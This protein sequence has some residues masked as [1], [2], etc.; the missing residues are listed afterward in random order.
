MKK[1]LKD[2]IFS[3][4]SYVL[5]I[6]VSSVILFYIVCKLLSALQKV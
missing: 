5:V 6:I 4:M 1:E 3:V 2:L